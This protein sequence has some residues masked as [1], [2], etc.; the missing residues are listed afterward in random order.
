MAQL[1]TC[2][3]LGWACAA[4]LDPVRATDGRIRLGA[5]D[6]YTTID[7]HKRFSKVLFN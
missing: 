7:R 6:G 2:A 3:A 1:I 5:A 4:H